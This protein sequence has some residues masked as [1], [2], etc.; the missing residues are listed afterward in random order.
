M[1]GK[2]LIPMPPGT[3]VGFSKTKVLS[4]D[5]SYNLW[6]RQLPVSKVHGPEQ[7]GGPTSRQIVPPKEPVPPATTSKDNTTNLTNLQDPV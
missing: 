7:S 2:P 5:Q 6:S 3:L 4:G 1:L